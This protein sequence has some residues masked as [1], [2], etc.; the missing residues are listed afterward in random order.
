MEVGMTS[1]KVYIET[2]GTLN[3]IFSTVLEN[4]L[5]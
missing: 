2:S 4:F 5:E 1:L 3:Y